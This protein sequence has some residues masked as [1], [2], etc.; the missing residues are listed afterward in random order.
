LPLSAILPGKPF[1]DS[2]TER[3]KD[4]CQREGFV[5]F[6]PLLEYGEVEALRED[7]QR[8]WNDP[9]MHETAR[10]QIRGNSLMRMFEYSYAF[11]DLIVREPFASLAESIL[12][13]DCHCMSQNAL[14]TAPNGKAKVN[15]PGGWHVDD[16]AH[17]PLPDHTPRHDP[18]IPLP[19]NVMQYDLVRGSGQGRLHAILPDH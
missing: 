14:Y 15:G 3:I 13:A 2:E 12:G 10:D 11:R 17:F 16:L 4:Q 5:E 6:G 8:K 19:C 18:S 9:R 1:N 7:L